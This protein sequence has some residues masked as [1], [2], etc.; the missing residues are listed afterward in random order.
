M[1]FKGKIRSWNDERGFGFIEP[2]PKGKDVFLHISAISRRGRRPEVGQIVTYALETDERGRPRAVKAALPGDR[3]KATRKKGGNRVAVIAACAFLVL[4]ALLVVFGKAPAPV[5]W[6]YLV[7]SVLTFLAYAFDKSAAKRGAWRTSEVT[8][9]WLAL[10]GGW[11]GALVA[12][13]TLRHKSRKQSFRLVF[14]ITVIVNLGVLVWMFTPSGA[15]SVQS[16]IGS[17]HVPA[18]PVNR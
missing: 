14:W 11:P 18:P 10:A 13:K 15:A 16:W 7:A 8:L 1:R 2:I 4:V 17:G 6:L 9:H 3:L 5:L 12:Q